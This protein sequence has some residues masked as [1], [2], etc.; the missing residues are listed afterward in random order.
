MKEEHE[1]VIVD[2]AD[3]VISLLSD[4]EIVNHRNAMI[5]T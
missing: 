1:F 5:T 3:Q 4:F 2:S